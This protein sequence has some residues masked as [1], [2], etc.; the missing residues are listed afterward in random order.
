MS[1]LGLAVM[2]TAAARAATDGDDRA[3]AARAIELTGDTPWVVAGSAGVP[4][5]SVDEGDNIEPISFQLALRDVQLDWYRVMGHPPPI[6]SYP[7]DIRHSV[8][9]GSL[10][11]TVTPHG[12]QEM[13]AK[14]TRGY[15][16][17]LDRYCDSSVSP[18]FVG[19]AFD[20]VQCRAKC[21]SMKCACFDINAGP[22]GGT[23]RVNVHGNGTTKSANDLTSYVFCGPPDCGGPAPPPPPPPPPRPPPPPPY[24]G[25]AIY[26]GT[27]AACPWLSTDFD[28]SA[29]KLER[30]AEAHCVLS[31][32]NGSS[33]AIVATGN[34]TRGAIY[35]LYTLAEKVLGVD[36]WWRMT[37][38]APAY[39]GTVS[40]PP[41]FREVIAPPA[42]SFRGVFTNDED[43]LGYFRHDPL[44][45]SVFDLHT[46]N[47]IYETLLRAKCNMI[48]PGTSPNPDE[49]HIALA[50]RRGLVTS[51]SHFEVMDFGAKEW[52]DGDVAPRGLY[53][54]TT[55]P[56]IMA[57]AW[58]A[59]IEANKDKDMIWT[60]GLRGLWDYAMCPND[61]SEAACGELVSG[62]VANQTAWIRAA[63][64]KDAKI[65]TYLWAELLALF[66][67]GH[68]VVPDGVKI[69]F[70]DAGKG[71]IGGLDDIHLAD[72]LYYHTAM[73]DG[74]S[75]QLVIGPH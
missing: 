6:L 29:C 50:N 58:R 38:H 40:V 18:T 24:N 45:E 26:V 61:M 33:T 48:I 44:G 52:L 16:E 71:H 7:L 53:N 27:L 63:D 60:V 14:P 36:P 75:N 30:G 37:D 34:G 41:D 12:R 2:A 23:C 46:W 54:W 35:A 31:V 10:H 22:K 4:V 25:P 28:L 73:L 20:E 66:K 70:T 49:K 59:A 3:P 15:I 47:M 74:G 67:S 19:H 5:S 42:F 21:D 17:L 9:D 56:D 69:V 13:S 65:I 68:L 57:H 51:Q 55:N 1:L 8:V 43:L 11:D 72:G 62:A 32:T 39:R 64:G